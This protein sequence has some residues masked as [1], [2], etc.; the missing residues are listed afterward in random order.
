M[1]STLHLTMFPSFEALVEAAPHLE[2]VTK[3]RV[4]GVIV[5]QTTDK[6]TPIVRT[7]TRYLKIPHA[8][9]NRSIMSL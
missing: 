2:G 3:G 4:G 8:S 9:F 5:D 7:T 6:H 1:F